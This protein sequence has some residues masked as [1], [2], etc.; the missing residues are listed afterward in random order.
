MASLSHRKGAWELRYRDRSGRQR[1]ERFAGGTTRRPPEQARDRQAE[2][3]RSLRRGNYIPREEREVPFETYFAKWSA[4]R[5]ISRSRI[6]SDEIRARL[7]VLPYWGRWRLCDIRPS[8][9]DDWISVL[10]AKMGPTSV[11]HC[12]GLLRGPLRRAVRDGI[13]PDPCIDIP[14]PPKPSIRKTFDD[15]LTAAETKALVDGVVD[16]DPRYAALRTNGRYIALLLLAC[17]CGPRWNEAIGVRLCDVNPLRKE[18]TF[19]RIVVCQAGSQTYTKVGSKTGDWRTVPVPRLV[20]DALQAHIAEYCPGA[21]REDFLFL[22][23]E[24]SHPLRS[25]F[26]RDVLKPALKRAGIERNITWLSLR[27]TAASLMFDAGLTLF[28]VQRRLGHR[29]PIMTAEIYTH[30][31]RERA[32]EGRRLVEDYME[33]AFG[34]ASPGPGALSSAADGRQP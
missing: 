30:L 2:V 19:G 22:S 25:N 6:H 13:I 29:S 12:Y 7:H 32:E 4:A 31:M 24:G 14:L 1:T 8:D 23:K 28:D 10:A 17:W 34:A 16:P 5:R 20:M 21:G 3:E 33:S 9:I 11:R 18:I 27:H 15:V 26:A